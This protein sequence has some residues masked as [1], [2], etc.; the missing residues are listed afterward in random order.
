MGDGDISAKEIQM[1]LFNYSGINLFG[2][3]AWKANM[4]L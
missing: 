1:D 3:D 2:S 4:I